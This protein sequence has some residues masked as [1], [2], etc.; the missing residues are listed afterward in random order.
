M[1]S[2]N[3]IWKNKKTAVLLYIEDLIMFLF[4]FVPLLIFLLTTTR[5]N[6][7][8]INFAIDYVADILP[9]AGGLS[10]YFFMLIV[11]VIAYFL[12]RIYLFSGI[13]PKLL[14]ENTECLK[15][16]G[17][18]F[19]KFLGLF[20]I[21]GIILLIVLGAFSFPFKKI[22]KD[23]YNLKQAYILENILKSIMI[24]L[25]WTISLFHTAARFKTVK[26]GKLKVFAK[27]EKILPFFGYQ[28]IALIITFLGLYL[29]Y[30][31]AITNT[32]IGYIAAFI[33]FQ[34]ALFFKITFKLSAYKS[35]A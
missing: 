2:L 30:K 22:L 9:K 24:F 19:R 1:K 33:I 31:L 21:Y 25:A 7:Y 18:N 27:P 35:I 6:Y 29:F 10:M 16:A 12:V 11:G 5:E 15:E 26:E 13:F 3:Y 32:Y 4:L 14:D 8:S 23:M 28:I 17:K 34:A 20:F